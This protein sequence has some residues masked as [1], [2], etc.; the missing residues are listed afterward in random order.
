MIR[1]Y[2]FKGRLKEVE[3][4]ETIKLMALHLKLKPYY[5]FTEVKKLRTTDIKLIPVQIA[6]NTEG[7]GILLNMAPGYDYIDGKRTDTQS[8]IK[9]EAVFPDNAFEKVLVK[10]PGTK[11]IITGEQ[12]AQ[13]GRAKVK[14]KNLTG[15][16]YRTNSGEYALSC[17]ADAVEVIQ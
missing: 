4:T 3:R 11:A 8:H 2:K 9:Y 1:L 17:S 16:F 14:F 12:L 6:G 10:V 7:T 5:K 13:S 15:K